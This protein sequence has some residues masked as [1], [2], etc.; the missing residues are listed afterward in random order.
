MPLPQLVTDHVTWYA[1]G[2]MEAIA[3]ILCPVSAIAKKRSSGHGAVLRWTIE[4]MGQDWSEWRDDR[5]MRPVPATLARHITPLGIQYIA[6]RAPQWHPVN[7]AMCVVKGE[8][9][10]E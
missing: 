6:F 4:P 7:Q 1:Y 2:Q 5:L 8:R 10:R 9:Q 3:D